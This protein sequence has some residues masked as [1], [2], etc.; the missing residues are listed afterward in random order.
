MNTDS[1]ANN[2]RRRL[3]AQNLRLPGPEG[4]HR[5]PEGALTPTVGQGCLSQKGHELIT[6]GNILMI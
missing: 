3:Q 4:A 5:V 6:F 2:V 1:D